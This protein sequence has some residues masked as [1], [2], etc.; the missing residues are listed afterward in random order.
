MHNQKT[1]SKEDDANI[2]GNRALANKVF[3]SNMA[4]DLE[5]CLRL[6]PEGFR[7]VVDMKLLREYP[8]ALGLGPQSDLP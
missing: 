4:S 5:K 2:P 6:P 8:A 1:S 7:R 3:G